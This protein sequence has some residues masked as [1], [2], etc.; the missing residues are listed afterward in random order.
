MKGERL[1]GGLRCSEVLQELSDYLDGALEMQRLN[2]V[3]DHLRGCDLCERF[4]GE[5]SA[6]VRALREQLAEPEPLSR[7]AEARLRQRLDSALGRD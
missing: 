7:D 1:V 3:E 2:Q 4:G 5:M 6:T